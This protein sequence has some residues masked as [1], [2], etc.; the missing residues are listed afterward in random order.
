MS[1]TKHHKDRRDKG[2]LWSRR[3]LAG[4][5]RNSYTKKLCRRLER[6]MK[7]RIIE[8]EIMENEHE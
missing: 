2:D 5:I 4:C 6:K 7:R 8:K 3:P 1:R